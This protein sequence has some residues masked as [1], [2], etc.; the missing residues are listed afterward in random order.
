[1]PNIITKH[2]CQKALLF[3][4]IGIIVLFLRL[5]KHDLTNEPESVVKEVE[6]E[7]LNQ[8]GRFIDNG[9]IVKIGDPYQTEINI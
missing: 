8:E 1:M 9:R 4:L 6:N 2:I 5:Y 3:E 7:R